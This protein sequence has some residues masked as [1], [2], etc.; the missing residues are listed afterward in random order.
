MDKQKNDFLIDIAKT[1]LVQDGQIPFTLLCLT[2]TK[3][4]PKSYTVFLYFE[5]E[6]EKLEAFKYIYLVNTILGVNS[7]YIITES[8]ML[9][10]KEKEEGR[11]IR[12]HFQKKRCVLIG[13]YK[14][15]KGTGSNT[16][17]KKV[18]NRFIF[19]ETIFNGIGLGGR[20]SQ[21]TS[22]RNKN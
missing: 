5:N 3:K 16:I 19:E 17:F 20:V 4:N 21:L 2:G 1:V 6:Q 18:N 8:W 11:E 13:Y 12:L 9:P 10:E 22:W 15:G 7:Y 14:D